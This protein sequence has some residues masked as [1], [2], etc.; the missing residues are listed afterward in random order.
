MQILQPFFCYPATINLPEYNTDTKH[1]LFSFRFS[2][3]MENVKHIRHQNFSFTLLLTSLKCEWC[4]WSDWHN[5]TGFLQLNASCMNFNTN[6][7]ISRIKGKKCTRWQ[8]WNKAPVSIHNKQIRGSA[9]I[10]NGWCFGFLIWNV[11]KRMC[12]LWDST[13][14]ISTVHLIQHTS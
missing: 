5:S 12:I 9:L 8:L 7:T 6:F 11:C 1:C 10:Q 14:K 3:Q 2:M 4:H 13:A